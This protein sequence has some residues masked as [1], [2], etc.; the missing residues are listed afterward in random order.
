M[1]Q[2]P[3]T[4]EPRFSKQLL[5]FII[6]LPHHISLPCA[7]YLLPSQI[8]SSCCGYHYFKKESI[9][10]KNTGSRKRQKLDY[11]NWKEKRVERHTHYL[12]NQVLCKITEQPSYRQITP[13]CYM[14]G[15]FI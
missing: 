10:I 1:D 9:R 2:Q 13:R 3:I 14:W 6:S 12:S 7:P 8:K 11:R 5:S 15:V 4:T